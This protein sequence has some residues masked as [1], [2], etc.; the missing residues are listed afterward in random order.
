MKDDKILLEFIL[1]AIDRIIR[2]TKDGEQAFYD[3]P[4]TQDA[5]L[6]N[7]QTLGQAARD[8][9]DAFR[10]SNPHIDWSDI[11]GFRNVV[12]HDYLGLD[13]PTVWSII[14]D[15]LPTLKEKIANLL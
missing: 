10:Q 12:V 9:S 1:E 11:I 7:F 15:E 5:V 13:L 14:V 3:D 6:R 4:K 8:V 2:Y